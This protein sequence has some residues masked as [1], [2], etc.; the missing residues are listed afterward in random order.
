MVHCCPVE[1]V[2][3]PICQDELTEARMAR[4]VVLGIVC[5]NCAAR[6]RKALL[7]LDGV[8]SADVD[9]KSGLALID[10]IPS[11]AGASALLR[12][13]AAAGADAEHCFQGTVIP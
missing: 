11:I 9:W 4:V 5:P 1:L 3:K 7:E 6:V 8:L 2:E 12:A 13:I 10:H